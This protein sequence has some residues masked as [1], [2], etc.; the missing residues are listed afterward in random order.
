LPFNLAGFESTC[1]LQMH[2]QAQHSPYVRL[3]YDFYSLLPP[4]LDLPSI[5]F[6]SEHRT[7]D[8]ASQTIQRRQLVL[9][10]SIA[11]NFTPGSQS[12]ALLF[13]SDTSDPSRTNFP[14]TAH[15]QRNPAC[16]QA[17]PAHRCNGPRHPERLPIQHQKIYTPAE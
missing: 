14:P 5:D 10:F 4:S 13:Q 11:Q 8:S 7:R 3:T 17:R 16:S 1:K 9:P 2:I 12:R 6:G 15:P